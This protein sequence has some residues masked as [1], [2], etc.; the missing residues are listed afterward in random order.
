MPSACS[1]DKV[2]ASA[3]GAAAD[4]ASGSTVAVGGFGLCGIPSVL[5]EALPKVGV[6]ELEAVS[7][8]ADGVWGEPGK[9]S[10]QMMDGVEAGRA[11]VAAR[12]VG[13]ALRAYELPTARP[14]SC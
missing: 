8:N 11:T 7:N 12:V 9:G 4:S 13:I 6:D 1:M 2:F 3:A 14:R 10:H 5:I